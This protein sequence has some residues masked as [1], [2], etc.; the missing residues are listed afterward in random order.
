MPHLPWDGTLSRRKVN[1]KL[2]LTKPEYEQFRVTLEGAVEEFEELMKTHDYY[3]T[4]LSDRL[5]TCLEIL[6]RAK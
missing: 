3:V 5:L 4:E 2:E 6:K 1:K